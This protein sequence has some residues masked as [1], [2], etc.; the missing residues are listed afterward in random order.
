MAR[1]RSTRSGERDDPLLSLTTPVAPRLQLVFTEAITP[2]VDLGLIEDRRLYNPEQPFNPALDSGGRPTRVV[3][4]SDPLRSLFQMRAAIS[5]PLKKTKHRLES[6]LGFQTPSTVMVCV[7]RKIRREVIF[8]KNKR[9]K[10]S[11]AKRHRNYHSN[12]RC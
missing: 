7:R 6:R 5:A 9:R 12:I 2:S 8:A 1:G 11:G 10:G 4:H 3:H